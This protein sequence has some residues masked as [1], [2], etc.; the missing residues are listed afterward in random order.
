MWWWWCDELQGVSKTVKWEP[1]HPRIRLLSL[2]LSLPGFGWGWRG[3]RSVR[4]GALGLPPCLALQEGETPGRL[5][6]DTT[7]P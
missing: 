6:A 4:V 2:I 1:R 5:R 3:G 7:L